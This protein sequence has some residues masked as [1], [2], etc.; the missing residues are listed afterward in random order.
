MKKFLQKLL[1]KPLALALALLIVL[2]SIS[3]AVYAL[4]PGDK[5]TLETYIRLTNRTKGTSVSY[6]GDD[7]IETNPGSLA[8]EPGDTIVATISLKTSVQEKAKPEDEGEDQDTSDFNVYM[9]NSVFQFDATILKLDTTV[10]GASYDGVLWNTSDGTSFRDARNNFAEINAIPFDGTTEEAKAITTDEN[11]DGFVELNNK[12]YITCNKCVE[13]KSNMNDEVIM[14][15]IF[16]V[17]EDV[18]STT[19]AS[20]NGSYTIEAPI[21]MLE[22]TFRSLTETDEII[23]SREYPGYVSS[24]DST[25][26]ATDSYD[27]Y[28]T[29][30]QYAESLSFGGSVTFDTNSTAYGGLAGG[31]L[32]TTGCT[33]VNATEQVDSN[34]KGTGVYS[35]VTL[36]GTALSST[37]TP[38]V[39]CS[40]TNITFLGWSKTQNSTSA[41]DVLTETE[42]AEITYSTDP[43]TLYAVY[44][45]EDTYTLVIDYDDKNEDGTAKTAK[46]AGLAYGQAI[47]AE[48][49]AILADTNHPTKTGSSFA[50]WSPDIGTLT[51]VDSS[52]AAMADTNKTLTITAT[53]NINQHDIKYILN[54]DTAYTEAT[55]DVNYGT[56]LDGADHPDTDS[57]TKTGYSNEG[58]WAYYTDEDCKVPY[59]GETMPDQNLYAVLQ[60]TENTYTFS[61]DNDNADTVTGE[62][63]TTTASQDVK[64]GEALT[65]TAPEKAG[66]TFSGWDLNDN[67]NADIGATTES[68]KID[69]AFVNSYL[70]DGEDE[71]T[72]LT[73]K[74]LWIQNTYTITFTSGTSPD[75][76][77]VKSNQKIKSFTY[78][79][80]DKFEGDK[81]IPT[82]ATNPEYLSYS[83]AAA[84]GTVTATGW[85]ITNAK[86]E[87][88]GYIPLPEDGKATLTVPAQWTKLYN[89]TFKFNDGKTDDSVSKLAAGKEIKVPELSTYEGHTFAYWYT[90]DEN[91]EVKPAATVDAD[92]PTDLTYIAKWTVNKH[93]V[94]Y[95]LDD[96]KLDIS[97]TE[98]P[99]GTTVTVKD[100][101]T[102]AEGYKLN[103][104]AWTVTGAT[105]GTDG[106][107]T[108]PDNDVTL[109][110]TTTAKNY[111]FIIHY[112]DY[113]KLGDK[114]QQV[115]YKAA[116]PEVKDLEAWTDANK[117]R[118]T[119]KGWEIKVNGVVVTEIPT[120]MPYYTVELTPVWDDYYTLTYDYNDGTTEK[121]THEIISGGALV[122]ANTPNPTKEGYSFGGWTYTDAS[123]A[124]I[125]K[126]ATMTSNI[127]ATAT[128]NINQYTVKYTIKDCSKAVWNNVGKTNEDYITPGTDYN[129]AIPAAQDNAVKDGY[130][131]KGWSYASESGLAFSVDE[132]TKMPAFNLVATPIFEAKEVVTT[133]K[134]GDKEVHNGTVKFDTAIDKDGTIKPAGEEG[135][136]EGKWYVRNDDGTKTEIDLKKPLDGQ[137]SYRSP[138][139]IE[140]IYTVTDKYYIANGVDKDG[141]FTYEATPVKTVN[142]ETGTTYTVPGAEVAVSEK[143]ADAFE[144]KGWAAKANDTEVLSLR[145]ALG[146]TSNNYYAVYDLKEYTVTFLNEDGTVYDQ[147]TYKY[148]AEIDQPDDPE[149]LGYTFQYW[150]DAD[151]K[152][153]DDYGVMPA[154]NLT[155]S[156][157]FM[158]N[159]VS[160]TFMK[161]KVV[162]DEY[163]TYETVKET[164]GEAIKTPDGTNSYN[165][166][167]LGYKFTGWADENGKSIDEYTEMPNGSMT[168]YAQ[169]ELDETAIALTVGGVVVSG[170]V[171][172]TALAANAALITTGAV[173]GGVAVVAGAAALA[174]HTHKV[175]YYVDGEVYK[176]YYCVEGT[177]VLT[178]D[179][180]SKDGYTFAGWDNEIPE[181]M[182]ANDLEFNATWSGNVDDEIPDTGSATAGLAAFAVISS[183]AAAA[184]VLTRKKKDEE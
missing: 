73:A 25:G 79:Y 57:Y 120:T 51:Q 166:F 48:A 1:K 141:N 165:P 153:V 127:T 152:K 46:F 111:D 129:T 16:K 103:E 92:N 149:K 159:D 139:T 102:P 110:L 6:T 122:D 101:A 82:A 123:G 121:E 45:N 76:S 56:S 34:N 22:G 140:A 108:M 157:Y 24:K 109:K 87:D 150:N 170:A 35:A 49:L 146:D 160:A 172:G 37:T 169:Y 164:V 100:L 145:G 136:E 99:Y 147:K 95:Y 27:I 36:A 43:T 11:A 154:K 29:Q 180:P 20:N 134:D 137:I 14:T 107:F 61:F 40:D 90:V 66:Y 54:D 131:F 133:I 125:S 89:V 67:G 5:A 8:V 23:G 4:Y 174:K 171:V 106:K 178:P 173:V 179:D 114:T 72:G 62:A 156:P 155:F 10:M 116:T 162:G 124:T 85:E 81:A 2:G 98:V 138:L 53:W 183:A 93:S 15:Y 151:G 143:Y 9:Y 168:F 70:K 47:P 50:A 130:D 118:H 33:N 52:F 86:I 163:V 175:T 126:P 71:K 94:T 17:S 88:G 58:E 30:K 12:S 128:W 119:F 7:T 176:T 80:G 104:T 181:K 3:V 84:G 105:V 74:A 177:K 132:N 182:P 63:A 42:L 112:G 69:E 65:L 18:N 161:K 41:A 38:S 184:Y 39:T 91:T 78:V 97:E 31:T 13:S 68:V 21:K 113:Q 64:F 144:F 44:S 148:G 32:D 75:G 19:F 158:S 26:F 83:D 59:T 55:E 96:A 117:I 115:A 142:D 167:K 28:L 60:W 135:K 77:G